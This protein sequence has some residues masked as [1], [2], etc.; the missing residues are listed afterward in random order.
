MAYQIATGFNNQAGLT[1]VSPQPSSDG[2]AISRVIYTVNQKAIDDGIYVTLW[3]YSALDQTSLNN[4]LSTMG[5]A[6]G[7]RT[8]EVTV[9][10]T[11]ETRSYSD[12]NAILISPLGYEGNT[13]AKYEGG[14]W[15]NVV[16]EFRLLEKLP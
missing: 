4:I 13:R 6:A 16:F 15:H 10:T 1:S 9:R 11:D 5:I 7:T 12:Y 14:F 3:R 8:Y 2:V